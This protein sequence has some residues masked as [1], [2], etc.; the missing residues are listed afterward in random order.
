[1]VASL[2]SFK[3][4]AIGPTPVFNTPKI[5]EIFSWPLNLDSQ[6]LLRAVEV[7]LFPGALVEIV[8][9][10]ERNIIQIKT[11]EYS[12]EELY[13]N[14]E[15][16]EIA[17]DDQ[18]RKRTCPP[19]AV[20]LKK[21]YHW[22]KTKYVWGGNFHKGIPL[23]AKLYPIPRQADRFTKMVWILKGVDCTGL[24]Y[25]AT[26]GFL[27]R[28]TGQLIEYGNSVSI[29]GKSDE[30]IAKLLI[31]GDLIV[32][33]GHALF[34]EGETVIE[35]RS[36]EGVVRTKLL[37]RLKEIRTKIGRIPVDDPAIPFETP[38]YVVRRWHPDIP[39]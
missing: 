8:A 9:L 16:L 24:L 31:P 21:F 13:T 5:S 25:E 34:V 27:P 3:M 1:M 18:P 20:I 39:A 37:K 28:N 15:F 12:G 36:P 4:R 14:K 11:D 22:P 35:S 2:E 30:E 29:F 7:I 38:S 10:K 33:R 19:L 32:W 17:K 6:K 26:N 23:L